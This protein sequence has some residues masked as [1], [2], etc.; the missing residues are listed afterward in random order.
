MDSIIESSYDGIYITDGEANT[1]RINKSYEEIT[2]LKRADMLGRNMRDLEEEGYISQSATLIVLKS[3]DSVTIQQKYKSGRKVMISST[4]I[5]N[6]NGEIS[7]VVTNVRDVTALAEMEELLEKNKEIAQKYYYE[8]ELMRANLVNTEDIVVED[9]KMLETIK[10]ANRVAKVDTIVLILGETGVGKEEIAKYIHKNSNRHDKQFLEINCG[11]IP[12]SLIEAELFGYE[13][14]AFTGA[15]KEGKIGL[16]EAADGGTLFLDE[17]GELPLD[18]Q[19]KLL[20]VLQKNEVTRIGGV[21]PIKIDVRIVAATNRELEEMVAQ[22]T[23]REDLYYRLNV[24]PILIPPLR[25]RKQDIMALIKYFLSQFNKKYGLNDYFDSD[26]LKCF[27][28]YN[29]PGNVRELKNAVERLVIMT[30]KEKITLN[31]LPDKYRTSFNDY[32]VNLEDG[33]IPLKVGVEQLEYKLLK[34]AFEKYGNVRGAAKALGID[35]STFVRKRKKY[36][37]KYK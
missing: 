28:E 15:N 4:P 11:A 33:I 31:D 6:E 21:K 14:G 10:L 35:A 17:I 16:F 37:E 12:H 24:V 26:V 2:G 3:S 29:W 34:R 13:R 7:L 30:D 1:L 19:V 20:R 23:F 9:H 18:M 32:G 27:Y 25:D 5:F 22:K 8:L 36:S